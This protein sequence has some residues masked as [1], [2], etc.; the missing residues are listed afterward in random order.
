MTPSAFHVPPRPLTAGARVCGAP[1][2]RS[3]R[4]SAPP[5]KKPTERL[6]GDQKGSVAP[7]VPASGC[8]VVV[9]SD[10]SHRRDAP[11][12]E[13]TKTICRPSGESA[14]DVGCVG[15]GR[16][17]LDARLGR[18]GW[19]RFAQMP[20]RG[21]GERDGHD[22]RRRRVRSSTP[23]VRVG[24]DDA[25]TR[26][27]RRGRLERALQRPGAR[28]RCPNRVAACDPSRGSARSRSTNAVRASSAGSA[29]Q[30]GSRFSTAASVSETRP[31]PRSAL[32]RQH[33]E[34][35]ARRTP[36]CRRACPPSSR[37]PAPGP[38]TPPC[39]GSS[40]P[41]VIAGVVIVGDCDTFACTPA[42]RCRW[43]HRLREAEVEHL[44]RAVGA[45]LDIRGLQIAMD[46]ALLVRRFERLRDLLRD[47]QR[48]VERNR[49]PRDALRRD[50]RPRRA[51]SRAR[52]RRRD[53]S[54]P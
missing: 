5:A 43:L 7:S 34:Q 48:L 21:N 50:P 23:A 28:R 42:S 20:H 44:H 27:L 26:R 33:L 11:S 12:P 49:A 6:S 24:A 32:S 13:A 38:C 37:A 46:D 47:R 18:R 40:R 51:P 39:R 35:H 16:D 29:V 17:D 8:A 54:S 31:R 22:T 3:S 4:F 9:A 45:H 19:R 25:A 14:N 2:P 41:C 53:S 30:S 52:G 1:P 15:G 36:R 10:R